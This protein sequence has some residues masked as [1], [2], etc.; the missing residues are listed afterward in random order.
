MN[1]EN[2]KS[3]DNRSLS[4]LPPYWSFH[5]NVLKT[6]HLPKPIDRRSTKRVRNNFNNRSRF[7]RRVSIHC[8]LICDVIRHMRRSLRNVCLHEWKYALFVRPAQLAHCWIIASSACQR[9]KCTWGNC[10]TFVFFASKESVV[11][12]TVTISVVYLIVGPTTKLVY[13]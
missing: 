2:G 9:T 8:Q 7:R 4:F 3:S 13:F 6:R 11:V 5:W 1:K 12:V 10:H